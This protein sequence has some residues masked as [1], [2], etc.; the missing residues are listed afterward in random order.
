[1]KVSR[2]ALLAV[3]LPSIASAHITIGSGTALANK[4]GQKIS[5]AINHG[6][7][8]VGGAKLDTLSIKV[9]IPTGIDPTTVRALPSDFGG[10]PIV[11]KTGSNV[12]SVTWVRN[13]SDL[14]ASDVAYYE[15]TLRLKVN[16]VPF[17]KIPWVITQVCRPQG[18]TVAD[19]V[20]V[21]W[22]GPS[23]NPEPSP[24]LIVVPAHTTGWHKIT[25][26]TAVAAADMGIFFGDAQI[27]WKGTSAFSS[28]AFTTTLITMTTGVT[29]LTTGL[30]SGDEIWVKY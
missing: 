11:A 15:L 10:T 24:N 9:D 25:M 17:T 1:M 2:F 6:C 19:D 26:T 5:F 8:G 7:D 16:D 12:T 18:G 4:T 28:N 20:T 14:Q 23:S 22:T 21:V 29:A 30:A 3:F 27:V 13:P